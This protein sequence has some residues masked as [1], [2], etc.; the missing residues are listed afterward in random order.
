MFW[1][2]LKSGL[3][4]WYVTLAGFAAVSLLDTFT[5]LQVPVAWK[6]YAI[7]A[8]ALMVIKMFDKAIRAAIAAWVATQTD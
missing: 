7:W 8:A 6:Y 2:A 3:R 4:Q 1:T 5:T